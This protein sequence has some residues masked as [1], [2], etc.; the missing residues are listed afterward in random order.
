LAFA[1]LGHNPPTGLKIKH[2]KSLEQFKKY[3]KLS[4]VSC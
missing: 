3:T 2:H 1:R 4:W